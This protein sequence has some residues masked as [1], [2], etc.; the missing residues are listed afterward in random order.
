MNL[1]VITAPPFE[2]VTLAECY[3]HLR[4]DPDH[5]GS[6]SETSHPDDA[7]LSAH[8]TAAREFVEVATRRALVQRTIR[9]SC[10]AWPRYCYGWLPPF[11]PQ[12]VERIMLRRPPV[13]RVDSVRYFDGENTLQTVDPASYYVTDDQVPELRFVSTFAAPTTFDRPDAVRVEYVAGYTPEGSPPT[14]QAEYAASIPATLKQCVLLGVQL[15]YDNLAPA[16]RMAV[17]NMR[18]AMLQ[19]YRVQHV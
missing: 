13:I 18:E 3:K 10:N 11:R 14:T 17:E 9:L 8:I 7:M 6:P 1:T 15:Q 4:L 2:P 5:E 16:D 12:Q 19:T